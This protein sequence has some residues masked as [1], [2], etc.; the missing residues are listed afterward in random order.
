MTG[1][2]IGFAM[3]GS[4]CTF[5]PAIR[6][7]SELCEQYA[8]VIPIFSEHAATLDTRFGTAAEHLRQ[9]EEICRKPVICTIPDAE[10]IGPKHLLDALVIAPCT[11]NTLAKLT[12]GIADSAVTFACKAH[13]RN[14]RPVILAVS[15]N[16]GL[17]AAAQNIGLLLNRKQFFFVPFGQDDPIHKPASLTA[18][19]SRLRETVDAALEGVQLQPV[20]R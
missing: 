6:A 19:L 18:D 8:S 7:L 20:L 13:L 14:G 15:T 1:K 12:A 16:D 10:P 2:T 11:G 17:A 9:V 4:F 5:A 3:T